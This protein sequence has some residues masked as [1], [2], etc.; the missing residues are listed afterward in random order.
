M[1]NTIEDT[2]SINDVSI[3]TSGHVRNMRDR[4]GDSG[5]TRAMMAAKASSAS[6][7]TKVKEDPEET[8]S[9]DDPEA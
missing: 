6:S 1:C 9:E 5:G 7:A 3:V 4:L 8:E 2:D